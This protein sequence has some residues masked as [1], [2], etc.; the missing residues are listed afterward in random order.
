MYSALVRMNL[1]YYI[2]NSRQHYFDETDPSWSDLK[3]G[4]LDSNQIKKMEVPVN[5]HFKDCVRMG[6]IAET[7]GIEKAVHTVCL[8]QLRLL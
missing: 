7:S 2:F 3:M 6:M 8:R 1:E 5:F 4:S